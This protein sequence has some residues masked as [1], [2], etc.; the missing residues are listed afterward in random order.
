MQPAPE[1]IIGVPTFRRPLWLRRCL[2]SLGQQK[3]DRPFGIVVADNDAE[4]GEGLA[5]CEEL[6][7][8]GFP[9][10]LKVVRV[11][12]RGISYTRNALVAEALKS[13]SVTAVAMLDDDEW[14]DDTWLKELLRVQAV[15]DADVVGGP[16]RRIFE[17][18]VPRYLCR[19]NQA[20]FDK[21]VD[22]QVSLIDATSNILFRADL[23]RRRA[24]PWFDPSYALMGGEDKDLLT[25]LKI[26]SRTFAWASRAYV[27]EEMPAS[28]CSQRWMLKRAYWVGNTDTLI[29]L[30]HR[31]PGFSFV[32]E[33]A[34]IGGAMC[35]ATFNV[36][37]FAWYPPRRFEGLRLG[38]RVLGKIVALSGGRHEE[39][40][41]VHGR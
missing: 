24:S 26:E 1:I 40:R 22:G 33:A 27:T 6:L 2:H 5:V 36:V 38:A 29:N 35:V 12:E 10:P 21:M 15:Y 23:F 37:L 16:V 9:V 39:Y 32:S 30:K 28:R 4:R 20:A 41:V 17:R 19:A 18:A 11:A 25:S 7:A 31:P 14:A 13:P 34:K 3:I 8:E